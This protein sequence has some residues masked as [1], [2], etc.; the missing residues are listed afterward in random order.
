MPRLSPEELATRSHGMGSTDVVEAAGLS[1]WRGAGPMRLYCEK[2]GIV[3]PDDEAEIEDDGWLEWGHVMEPVIAGWYERERGCKLMPA[4]QVV[5]REHPWLWSTL[6][7]VVLGQSRLV[8]IKNVGSPKLYAHWSEADPDGIP[9][10]VRA[11]ATIGMYCHGAR[12]CAVVASV[13]GRP[14]HVWSVGYDAELADMLVNKAKD[15]WALV[16]AKTPPPLDATP[17]TK[18]YLLDR[19]PR[20]VEPVMIDAD[21]E[22]DDI[23]HLRADNAG[24]EKNHKREKDRLDAE[25]LSRVGNADGIQGTGWMMTWKSDKNGLRRQRFTLQRG[26][27]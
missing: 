26:R 21:P 19:Y 7:A 17:A 4:G 1:P 8:E 2:L 9:I 12:E 24:W 11:Q 22:T 3:S 15:F 27:E 10:Y 18:A 14:P 20:N 13:G 23:G 6:D 5:S 25:L 16:Q